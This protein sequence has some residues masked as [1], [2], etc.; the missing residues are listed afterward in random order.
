MVNSLN[1]NSMIN[2]IEYKIKK[3]YKL[4]NICF[5]KSISFSKISFRRFVKKLHTVIEQWSQSERL[6]RYKMVKYWKLIEQTNKLDICFTSNKLVTFQEKCLR[7]HFAVLL[8]DY[9]FSTNC[10]SFP[11]RKRDEK[12]T[13]E[14]FSDVCVHVQRGTRTKD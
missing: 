9:K 2:G 3:Q 12:G 14:S 8:K 1:L 11:T 13:N 10:T 6:T 4:P 7:L 5:R